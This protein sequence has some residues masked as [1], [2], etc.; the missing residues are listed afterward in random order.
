MR[1]HTL[2]IASTACL[3]VLTV[4][5]A[6]GASEKW[7]VASVSFE[8]N[9]VFTDGDLIGVMVTQPSRFLSPGPFYPS[10]LENDVGGLERFYRRRGY[11]QARID[12]YEVGRDST[13]RR[14]EIQIRISEGELTRTETVSVF[15]NTVFGDRLLL[16]RI[17]LVT[18]DPLRAKV[19]EDATTAIMTMYANQGY[20]D[21]RVRPDI[22]T[23]TET[24]LAIVDF[25]I[26]EGGQFRIAEI[27][28]ETLAKTKPDVVRRELLFEP[29]Q[30]VEYSRLL[31]S[32]RRLYLTGLFESVFI[33]P[34]T[35]AGADSASK[36]ILIEVKERPSIELAAAVGY[37]TV[38]RARGRLEITND[39]IAGSARKARL[40]GEASF[41]KRGVEVSVTEPWTLGIPM[42]T[43]L[44]VSYSYIDEPGYE[45]ERKAAQISIGRRL[46]E[47]VRVSLAYRYADDK[48]IKLDV[49]EAPE[50]LSINLRTLAV[51]VVRDTRGDLFN[52]T[53]GTYLE[54]SNE[55]AGAIL[56][57]TNTF[58]R[59][60]FR[61][62][63]FLSLTP[64]TTVGSAM[65]LGWM[66]PLGRSDEIP[67]GERFYTGG[68]N[69]LRGFGYQ[70]VGPLDRKGTPVGGSFK[71]V[72]N[73]IEIRQ[74]LYK[75]IGC[76]V[77]IDVGNVWSEAR[78]F[79]VR[80]F[81]PSGGGGIRINTPIGIIRGDLGVN[82][83]RKKG[84]A[85]A[86]FH[87][88]VG[89]AF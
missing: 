61:A 26:E 35:P 68:P 49:A 28:T 37:G 59:S 47:H 31:R 86:K 41:I 19:I 21:A 50:D 66:D 84:E 74:D 62:K 17:G 6:A 51:S 73:L 13:R 63:Y 1:N 54:W 25:L 60:V 23:N 38:E 43:D 64:S 82:F 46:S 77:F 79:H 52:P 8:G 83:D 44:S 57:G 85:R 14:V 48:L 72:L 24:N 16:E 29:G 89:Q 5:A 9:E 45:L 22:Q 76:A 67:I 20:L 65:E 81:R 87:F 58:A 32:Q 70:L 80:G 15:G 33:R 75:I 30:V 78:S 56:G 27:R 42:R 36:D 34:Q 7:T 3:M 11:L 12:G 2:I 88:N 69:S 55:L 39:N 10:V 71:S 40:V 53:S 18:G 4:F